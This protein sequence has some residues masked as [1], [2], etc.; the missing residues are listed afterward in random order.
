MWL[1]GQLIREPA[2]RANA[3]EDWR[4]P[5]R[6]CDNERALENVR[7]CIVAIGVTLK[8]RPVGE[9]SAL[10]PLRRARLRG[11]LPA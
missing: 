10:L 7:A 8:Q 4:S 3:P 5:R 9:T 2:R 1:S 6:G 11:S